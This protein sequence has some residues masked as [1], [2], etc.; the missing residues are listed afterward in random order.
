[1]TRVL[2]HFGFHKTGTSTAER[3]LTMNG[4]ILSKHFDCV[5]RK[6]WPD[7]S[8]AAKKFS[9]DQSDKRLQTFEAALA[10]RLRALPPDDDK[11]LCISNVDLAGRIPGYV[12]VNDYGAVPVLVG[13]LRKCIVQHFG[14]EVNLGFM[15][16]QRPAA[17]WIK[18]LY[19]QNLKVH[20]L[21]DDFA[22]FSARFAP[23]ADQT[24]ILNKIRAALGPFSLSTPQLPDS[25][26]NR[27]GP[28]T[29]ILTAMG[30][31]KGIMAA[32]EPAPRLKASMPQEIQQAFLEMNQSDLP[33]SEVA[34]AK[35]D[36]LAVLT[37]MD[38]ANL[39]P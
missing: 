26:Q 5:T 27:L 33:D 32:L 14:A 1:M 3:T 35:S 31:S 21:R 19:W 20:R 18:S 38:L 23:V 8:L 16:S 7:V 22:T 2:V 34:T 37:T 39:S 25:I 4:G 10:A 11:S 12:G 15:A 17:D 9:E 30:L 13:A 28:A 36:A 24:D 29:P 6:S